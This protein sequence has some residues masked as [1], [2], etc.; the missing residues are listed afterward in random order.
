M[1]QGQGLVLVAHARAATVALFERTLR[2]YGYRV[3]TAV[4]RRSLAAARYLQ[5]DVILLGLRMPEMDGVRLSRHLKADPA[6]AQIPIVALADADDL[7][8]TP[9]LACEDVLP[10]TPFN[11][12]RLLATVTRWM[13][14]ARLRHAPAQSSDAHSRP[15]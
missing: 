4:G 8:A 10:T 2:T 14:T 12:T 15:R 7:A 5:P 1:T 11:V 9:A 13:L 3:I 6:T